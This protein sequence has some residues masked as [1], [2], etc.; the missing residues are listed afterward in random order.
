MSFELTVRE[1]GEI[2]M[3]QDEPADV[4]CLL[5]RLADEISAHFHRL[6][7]N[8]QAVVENMVGHITQILM[9]IAGDVSGHDD[10]E[11][12]GIVSLARHLI[13]ILDRTMESTPRR[14]H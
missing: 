1:Q 3:D 5:L 7:A 6:D 10:D 13:G 4:A 14:L 12:A 2:E 8:G 9:I 11:I